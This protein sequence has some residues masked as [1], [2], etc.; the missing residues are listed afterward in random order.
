[1][2]SKIRTFTLL[3]LFSLNALPNYAQ[4]LQEISTPIDSLLE[5]FDEQLQENTPKVDR[6]T[7]EENIKKAQQ[8]TLQLNRVNHVV[9]QSLDTAKLGRI[10]P[11]AELFS[12]LAGT[13]LENQET[14]MNLRFLNALENWMVSISEELTNGERLISNRAAQLMEVRLKL[15]SIQQDALMRASLRDTTLLPEYQLTISTLRTNL[16]KTD[17]TLNQQRLIAASYQSRA[18]N[19]IIRLNDIKDRIIGQKRE[20]ERALFEKETNF[21]WEPRDFPSTERLIYVFRDSVR[22]NLN[23][24]RNYIINHLGTTFFLLLLVILFY[25]WINKNLKKIASN[26]EF[27]E[28]ILGRLKYISKNTLLS[29]FLVITSLAPFFY[30]NPPVPLFSLILV[31]T[32]SLSGILLRNRIGEDSFKVWWMMFALFLISIA[33]NLYWEVAYQERWH[34][35]VFSLFG[36]YIGWN[37]IQLQK[38][39]KEYLPAYIPLVART[40]MILCGISIIA[41]ILGRFSLS[42]MIGITATL[43]LMHAVPL[44]IVVAIIKEVIYL[45]IEVSQKRENDFTSSIDFYDIQKRVNRVAS[46]LAV[47]IWAYFFAESLGVFDT[48][49]LEARNFLSKPRNLLN[50]S[51]TYSQVAIF[52]LILYV[53]NFLA[54]TVA[55]LAAIKDQQ[56]VN[57]RS[58]KLGSSILLIRLSL[59]IV[60]FLL[61]AAASGISLDKI[62]IVLGAFSLGISFGLQTIVNNLVSGIILAF[63]KPIQIGDTVQV[64]NIEGIVRD[65]GI[66]ASKIK[67]WDGAEVIIPNGDLLAQHLTNWTLSDKQRRVELIIGVSYNSDLDL[68][69]KLIQ[70][71]LEVQGILNYPPPRILLQT[72]ADNSVNFRVLFWVEDVDVWVTIRDQVMRGIFKSFKD[73]GVEIPFPQRDLHIKSFP[74]LIK[75][76]LSKPHEE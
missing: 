33:S 9:N 35:L 52:I 41:N 49:I 38:E 72:F 6:L 43:S 44:I 57:V 62:A 2:L 4:V 39:T 34:L 37:L 68:V 3:L 75:E 56:S 31:I 67:N 15:D 55:Y 36:I 12:V 7:L 63:E 26:K 10:L 54:N 74:G 14:K 40:Y 22:F 28:L 48:I 32:V 19:L 16:S 21:I 17:S 46:F 70:D 25:T 23:I 18:S 69:T 8:Y 53:A 42:K 47:L 65:I 71:Q 1:M 64:G 29:A 30:P 5:F 27:S 51:F 11:R 76:K 13:R 73:N 45:M 24:T 50:A 60:G 59:L 61:A 58:K 20:L 66:R